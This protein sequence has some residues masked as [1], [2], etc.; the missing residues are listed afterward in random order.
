MKKFFGTALI[1]VILTSMF[2]VSC[3]QA[4]GEPERQRSSF[5]G[6]WECSYVWI[7]ILDENNI[8][9][10]TLQ[11][12]FINTNKGIKRI[13]SLE[14]TGGT[15]ILENFDYEINENSDK[16]KFLF[17]FFLIPIITIIY[18]SA[19]FIMMT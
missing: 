2:L 19:N 7:D 14:K 8:A 11:Y 3:N 10:V 12:E 6:T 1:A 13:K 15:W 5:I 18:H 17:I 4:T 16:I 9:N